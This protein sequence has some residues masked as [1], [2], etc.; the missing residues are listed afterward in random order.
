M[1]KFLF[2]LAIKHNFPGTLRLAS[3]LEY[4]AGIFCTKLQER[5]TVD[6]Y[7]ALADHFTKQAAQEDSHA[8]ILGGLIDGKSRIKRNCPGGIASYKIGY[9]ALEGIS[10]RYWSAKLFFGFKSA[11]TFGWADTIA[12]IHVIEE[13]VAVFYS[14]LAECEDESIKAI[15][16]KI[17]GDELHHANYAKHC[18]WW[19]HPCPQQVIDKWRSRLL[20]AVLGGAIDLLQFQLPKIGNGYRFSTKP[21]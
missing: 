5:A 7:P 2:R 17:Q 13:V 8:R 1:L 15:A 11:A 4:G 3:R 12:F 20:L 9:E 16:L 6:G 18:L 10:Q 19:F 21:K 14:V